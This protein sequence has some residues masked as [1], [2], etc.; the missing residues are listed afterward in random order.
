MEGL[1][2]FE[3]AVMDKL[4][5][6]D[7]PTLVRL[8]QQAERASVKSRE[9]TGHGIFVNFELPP[10]VPRLPAFAANFEVADVIAVIR[11]LKHDAGFALFVRDGRL[12]FLDGYAFIG[13]WPRESA[14][15]I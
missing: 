1:T 12:N 14:A 3:R 15:I 8:R 7:H 10:D 5:A 9:M 6:G 13:D 11:G 4:L 2:D